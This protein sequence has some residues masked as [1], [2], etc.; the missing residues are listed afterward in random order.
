[1]K[2]TSQDDDGCWVMTERRSVVGPLLPGESIW[3]ALNRMHDYIDWL[4]WRKGQIAIDLEAHHEGSREIKM[5]YTLIIHEDN[6]FPNPTE[7]IH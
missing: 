5:L 7:A 4:A 3:T 2:T 1:M 6:L